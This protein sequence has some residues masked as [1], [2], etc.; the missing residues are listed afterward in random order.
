MT[1]LGRQ[2]VFIRLIQTKSGTLKCTFQQIPIRLQLLGAFYVL[3]SV[4]YQTA[5]IELLHSVWR[6][7]QAIP[8]LYVVKFTSVS[9]LRQGGSAQGYSSGC[10]C[11]SFGFQC[12]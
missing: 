11:L 2:R 10:L 6:P 7:Q 1:I 9:Q 5:V 4:L 12:P 8:L 3:Q